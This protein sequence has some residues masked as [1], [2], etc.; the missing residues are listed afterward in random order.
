MSK[1]TDEKG[2][3]LIDEAAKAELE[4]KRTLR[5]IGAVVSV[6]V[7]IYLF[8]WGFIQL[9]AGG[10]SGPSYMQQDMQLDNQNS[11]PFR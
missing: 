7:I 10:V 2:V 5:L 9:L 1:D 4:T 8:G 6:L 11:G 3:G